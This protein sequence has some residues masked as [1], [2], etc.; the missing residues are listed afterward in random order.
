MPR[1]FFSIRDALGLIPDEEGGDFP[2]SAV[3]LAEAEA[4]ARDLAKQ[5]ID[6]KRPLSAVVEVRDVKGALIAS[7]PLSKAILSRQGG[8]QGG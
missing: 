7:I 3:A 2:S 6:M 8:T 5:L 4:T 1:Y